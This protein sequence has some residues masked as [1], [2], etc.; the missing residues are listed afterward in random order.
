MI[1]FAKNCSKTLMDPTEKLIIYGSRKELRNWCL[2]ITVLF[3]FVY[4]MIGITF[5]CKGYLE[6]DFCRNAIAFSNLNLTLI[7]SKDLGKI[8]RLKRFKD[9]KQVQYSYIIFYLNFS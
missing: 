3:D 7:I 6:C 8:E 9:V 4:G 5:E 1:G 2:S